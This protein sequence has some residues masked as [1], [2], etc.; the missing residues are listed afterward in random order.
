MGKVLRFPQKRRVAPPVTAS[1]TESGLNGQI[2]ILP[3]VHIERHSA[4]KSGQGTAPP[5]RPRR[6]KRA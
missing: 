5:K 3:V 1:A 2:I 6:R 4:P